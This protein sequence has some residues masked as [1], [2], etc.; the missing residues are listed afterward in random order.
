MNAIVL[1]GDSSDPENI[2]FPYT[3]GKPKA[4]VD[5]AGKPMAQ[6]V[7]D[8]L[9]GAESVEDVHVVGLDVECGLTCAKPLYFLPCQGSMLENIKAGIQHTS[10][11]NPKACHTLLV[12]CDIPA[13][14]PEIVDW[15][16]NTALEHDSDIDYVVVERRTMEKRFPGANRSYVRLKDLE[17]C[18]GDMNVARLALLEQ[19]QL[20]LQIIDARKNAL[21]QAALI[22]IDVLL[23]LLLKRI[24]LQD[25]ERR[26]SKRLGVKG[27]ACI[28]PYAEVAMDVDKPH[29][30]EL[31]RNDLAS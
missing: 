19:E 26:V 10:R 16:V 20:W 29:Q 30:L 12:S 25:A 22:G 1:A 24:S 23:L 7:L 5:V 9:A 4:L 21:K 11:L 13:I 27:R 18:G 15:R 3:Q 8:A 17:L 14:T 31:M 28:S 6:W 2:L